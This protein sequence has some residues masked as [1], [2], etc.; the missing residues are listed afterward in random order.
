MAGCLHKTLKQPGGLLTKAAPMDKKVIGT[1]FEEML[2]GSVQ[3]TIRNLRWGSKK[4]ALI[5]SLLSQSCQPFDCIFGWY[6]PEG[7]AHW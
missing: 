3:R 4:T 5:L 7:R 2:P 6:S 1:W